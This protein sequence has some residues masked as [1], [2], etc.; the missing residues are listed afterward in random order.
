MIEYIILGRIYYMYDD[1]KIK[2]RMKI[3]LEEGIK[4]REF[5][6][7]EL[8]DILNEILPFRINNAIKTYGF[9]IEEYNDLYQLFCDKIIKK[10]VIYFIKKD[11]NKENSDP[12][13]FHKW[14]NTVVTRTLYDYIKKRNW[15]NYEVNNLEDN[16]WQYDEY[17][18]EEVN[19]VDYELYNRF[20]WAFKYVL[21]MKSDAQTILIWL[22]YMVKL[23][24]SKENG[25]SIRNYLLTN[26]DN[27]SLFDLYIEVYEELNKLEWYSFDEIK[28]NQL[29][30]KLNENNK[31]IMLGNRKL[32]EFLSDSDPQKLSRW[33]S[34]TS[35]KV[36]K[37][38]KG[39]EKN[40][41]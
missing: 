40:E 21:N 3:F 35:N 14:I 30:A 37:A 31:G 34:K 8:L 23:C 33:I 11:P 36:R 28:D 19:T 41:K 27:I 18:R 12:V 10:Y 25:K 2:E 9:N 29:I 39:S 13:E 24:D 7:E 22:Y 32:S 5:D 4:R 17:S 20:D 6:E 26:K 1:N 16:D 15:A 38:E